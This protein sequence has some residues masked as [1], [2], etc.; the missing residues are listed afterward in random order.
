MRDGVLHSESTSES[1]MA[2][3]RKRDSKAQQ[4]CNVCNDN[5]QHAVLSRYERGEGNTAASLRNKDIGE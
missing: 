5:I 4:N 3:R 1:P 2:M